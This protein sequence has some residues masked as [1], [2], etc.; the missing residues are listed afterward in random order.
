MRG[1]VFCV[2]VYVFACMCLVSVWIEFV[3]TMC[4]HMRESMWKHCVKW[5]MWKNK[6][7]QDST[8]RQF[9]PPLSFLSED[10][11]CVGWQTAFSKSWCPM[12]S[13]KGNFGD[14]DSRLKR[15]A[16]GIGV[17]YNV[18]AL[19]SWIL[20]PEYQSPSK[21]QCSTSSELLCLVAGSVGT[22]T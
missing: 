22:I 10:S 6:A 11:K 9:Q 15:R 17:Y 8:L 7:W 18:G 2:Y 12:M 14:G 5:D 16:E 13:W 1:R 21:L 20:A 19:L 4:V 3:C